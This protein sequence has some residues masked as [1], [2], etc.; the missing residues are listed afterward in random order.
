M[1]L[2]V[3]PCGKDYKQ[4]HHSDPPF[5][6]NDVPPFKEPLDSP[7]VLP[8]SSQSKN[9]QESRPR[10]FRRKTCSSSVLVGGEEVNPSKN[11]TNGASGL[12]NKRL[13]TEQRASLLGA[14]TLLGAPGHHH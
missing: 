2:D 7:F 12:T 1:M 13:R 10:C 11:A 8:F 5:A 9:P 6:Q 3:H 14:R 4:L